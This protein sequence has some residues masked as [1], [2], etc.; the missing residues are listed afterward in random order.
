MILTRLSLDDFGIFYG[1]QELDLEAGLYVVHGDNGRG[2]TTLINA[3][4]WAFFGSYANRQGRTVSPVVILNRDAAEEGTTQFRVELEIDDSGT[5]Y[6]IR[7][8]CV[9]DGEPDI[10]LYVEKDGNSLNQADALHTLSN[11]LN[12]G[13]A[14]FFLF[15][16]EQLREYEE[17]LFEEEESA[18]TVRVSI[19]QILGL[20]VLENTIRDLDAVSEEIGKE[21]AKLARKNEKTRKLGLQATQTESDIK[22]AE[23]D[24]RDM[25]TLQD[26]AEST[27]AEQEKILQKYESSQGTLKKIE[28]AEQDL[29]S[30]EQARKTALENRADALTGVWRDVLHAA[31]EPRR[32]EVEAHL[33]KH[34]DLEVAALSAQQ[35]KET[36][37]AG[38]CVVCGQAVSGKAV[39]MLESRL[40][41]DGSEG[42]GGIDFGSLQQSLIGL[43]ALT[44]TGQLAQAV[45][46]DEQIAE[47]NSREIAIH[48]KLSQLQETV[49]DVPE[50]EVRSAAKARDDAQQELGQLKHLIDTKK[51]EIANL[52]GTLADLRTKIGE[53]GES[54]ELDAIRARENLASDLRDLFDEAKAAYRD[55]LRHAVEADASEIFKDLTTEPAHEGLR[56][57]ESYG[58]ETI[59]ADGEVIGERSA[60]QEQIVALALIG[61]LNRNATRRAPVMMDTP[62]GRLDEK[63]RAN[64]LGFLSKMADQT[65]LLVHSA[66]VDPDDLQTIASDIRAEYELQR[67]APD[68]TEIRMLEGS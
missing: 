37:E 63:H 1:H 57:N 62:F 20:P 50:G 8:T 52:K 12:E 34:R 66:E 33:E 24:L 46:H 36:I 3:V 17:L 22:D 56:I 64:V 61:A 4:R 13:I 7:R 39:Q 23:D 49:Q 60:G 51:S 44:E 54:T 6:L 53:E 45:K 26:Q 31:V 35:L 18:R 5:T 15:D 55:D 21:I 48:Q 28:A 65:F 38:S 2:K 41:D 47:L 30:V 58:L 9:L 59:G 68:K 32:S 19:E 40:N 67:A 43:G 10:N 42:G 29:Q 11:L 25:I 16:G 27:V 14:R